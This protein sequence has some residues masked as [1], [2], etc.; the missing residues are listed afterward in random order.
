MINFNFLFKPFWL[1]CGSI[2]LSHRVEKLSFKEEGTLTP[3]S[4]NKGSMDAFVMKEKGGPRQKT[5]NE[6]L[7]DRDM[8]VRDICRGNVFLFNLVKS[9]VFTQMVKSIFEY[10]RCL[11]PP[12]YYEVKVTYLKKEIDDI[13]TRLEIYMDEWKKTGCTLMSDGWTDGKNRCL[14]N[15]L[16]NSP[17][18]TMFIKSIDASG[19]IK[20]AEKMFELLDSM[21]DEIGEKNVAQV[22]TD[23]A[24][25]L[26]VARKKLMEKR[27]GLFWTPCSAHCLDLVLEDIVLDQNVAL[28]SMFVSEEWASNTYVGKDDGDSVK[29]IVLGDSRFWKFLTYC[30]SCV[31]PLVKVLRLVDGDSKPSMGYIY[32]VMDRAKEHIA[33]NFNN[34][35][36]GYKKVWKI[37]DERWDYQL[38]RPLY[39]ARYYLNPRCRD[40]TDEVEYEIPEASIPQKIASVLE[41][42]ISSEK[43]NRGSHEL[44]TKRRSKKKMPVKFTIN[45]ESDDDYDEPLSL[46]ASELKKSKKRKHNLET[47]TVKNVTE[48]RKQSPRKKTSKS[49]KQLEKQSSNQQTT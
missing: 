40:A 21:V 16:V 13:N 18:G 26:V 28:Q 8:V 29:E 17:R 49:E 3:G 24:S 5:L 37:I 19:S 45:L 48:K 11:K 9:L 1:S 30:C 47:S 46:R 6:M 27:K 41:H 25:A 4:Q 43:P 36:S 44:E 38:H 12:S 20:D 22:V 15:F 32:K 10:G 2:L 39:A 23:S 33:N 31:S 35:E 7:K 14:I 34:V 42:P